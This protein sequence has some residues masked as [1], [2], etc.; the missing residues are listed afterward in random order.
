MKMSPG[1]LWRSRRLAD[2]DGFWKMVAI[3]QRTPLFVPIAEKRGTKEPPREDVVEVKRLITK[4]LSP[5][6]SALLIDPLYGYA[7]CINELPTDTG[8]IIS[9]EHSITENTSKGRKSHPIPDW[10]VAKTRAVGGDACKVLAWYRPDA[11]PEIIAHQQAFVQKAGEECAANDMVMLLELLI[12]PL[13]GED[14]RALEAKREELVLASLEPFC[15]PKYRID[16]YKVEPP[17]LVHNVPDPD[18]KDAASLQGAYDRMGKMLPRPWVM[19]SAGASAA[20]FERSMNFAYRAGA[21]G[22]LAGRAVWQDAFAHFPDYKAMEKGLAESSLAILDRLNDLTERKGT[23]W[24][25]HSAFGG[26][27]PEPD[28]QDAFPKGYAA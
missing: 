17:G 7:N 28:V 21:S 23:P 3:D 18:S 13:P 11:D 8:L 26:K 27:V 5:K 2:K 9:Y 24:Y 10:S 4:H 12:Y 1:K 14:P 15:D 25:R 19:L 6:A 16:I 20:D 22:Y